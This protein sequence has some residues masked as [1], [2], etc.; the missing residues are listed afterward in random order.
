MKKL[1]L[2]ALIVFGVIGNLAAMEKEPGT[3][4]IQTSEQE[5]IISD[6]IAKII[7]VIKGMLEDIGES[8]AAI[9]LPTVNSKDFDWIIQ[10]IKQRITDPDIK[11]E[12]KDPSAERLI[13]LVNSSEFL[14]LEDFK[15]S[16][17]DQLIKNSNFVNDLLLTKNFNLTLSSLQYLWK[18]SSA[19]WYIFN[20]LG[21]VASLESYD[22]YIIK[23][24]ISPDS[25]KLILLDS[26]SKISIRDL[27]DVYNK[28]QYIIDETK[29]FFSFRSAEKREVRNF[30]ITPDGNQLILWISFLKPT[31]QR[32][33]VFTYVEPRGW[34]EVWDLNNLNNEPKRFNHNDLGGSKVDVD[35]F[36]VTPNGKKL[37]M[38]DEF[39]VRMWDLDNLGAMPYVISQDRSP[40]LGLLVTPDSKKLFVGFY[41]TDASTIQIFDVGTDDNNNR[42]L[43][44]IPYQRLSN[45][46][47]NPD[48]SKLVAGTVFGKVTIFDVKDDFKVFKTF[49]GLVKGLI[50]PD[51]K[52][53][54]CWQPSEVNKINRKIFVYDMQSLD[55]PSKSLDI[56]NQ[57]IV[58]LN[59]S[60]IIGWSTMDGSSYVWNL[61]NLNF[62]NERHSLPDRVGNVLVTPDGKK[63]VAWLHDDRMIKIWDRVDSAYLDA[64][65]GDQIK[66]MLWLYGH[67]N[68]TWYQS[69]FVASSELRTAYESL[70]DNFKKIVQQSFSVVKSIEGAR[71]LSRIKFWQSKN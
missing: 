66:L 13:S 16:L 32:T 49:E 23:A 9:P 29:S 31:G 26:Y 12:L 36:I 19:Y 39:G 17:L 42:L 47:L 24:V 62:D 71:L 3:V 61:H 69:L 7:P 56:G 22:S 65:N 43:K 57:F 64:L 60:T 51:N 6:E 55:K 15:E 14:G 8:E 35:N 4:T 18:N 25:K 11:I 44:T 58:T 53:L 45:I 21:T 20:L 30:A 41:H 46:T 5:F 33:G 40:A 37:I 2:L 67:R 10:I 1:V 68:T 54:M 70:S 27:I 34:I 50:T 38:G 48:G 63:L 59:D 52:Y 28:P